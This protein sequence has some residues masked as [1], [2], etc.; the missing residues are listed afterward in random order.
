MKNKSLVVLF[1]VLLVVSF[2]F[3]GCENS[4]GSTTGKTVASEL[5]GKWEF[6]KILV[7]GTWSSLPVSTGYM[8]ISSG[9]YEFTSNVFKAYMNGSLVTTDSG[10]YTEGDGL[11][12]ADGQTGFTY[13]IA[14]DILTANEGNSGVTAKKVQKFS[15]E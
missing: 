8:T 10:V 1:G 5:Q 2:V 11:Y 15:W 9:G 4:T 14:G 12:D 3:S 13:S 7:S 6:D